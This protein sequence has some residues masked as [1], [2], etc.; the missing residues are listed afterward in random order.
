MN[1]IQNLNGVNWPKIKSVLN[2]I[3]VSLKAID[4][5]LPSGTLKDI[6]A[7][8]VGVLKMIIGWLPS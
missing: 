3:L 4:D 1:D 7:G 2:D 6:L 5:E 8:I